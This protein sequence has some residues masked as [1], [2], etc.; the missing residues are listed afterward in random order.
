MAKLRSYGE[1]IVTLLD[2]A[3]IEAGERVFADDG[4]LKEALDLLFLPV[5]EEVD[6]LRLRAV[7]EKATMRYPRESIVQSLGMMAWGEGDYWEGKTSLK[8]SLAIL[9]EEGLL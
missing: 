8:I 5:D 2:K 7:L 6:I 4:A 1:P 3:I 9:R